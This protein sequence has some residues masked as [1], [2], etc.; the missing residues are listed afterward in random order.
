MT[1]TITKV[2]SIVEMTFPGVRSDFAPNTIDK[3]IRAMAL[4]TANPMKGITSNQRRVP[5][6]PVKTFPLFLISNKSLMHL[7]SGLTKDLTKRM[8][9][10][11]IIPMRMVLVFSATR[12]SLKV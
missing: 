9:E 8:I 10:S 4:V 12:K 7:G 3:T 1:A 2:T 5:R 11:T 6:V